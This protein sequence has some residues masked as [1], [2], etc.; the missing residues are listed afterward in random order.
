M[1]PAIAAAFSFDES[2]ELVERARPASCVAF[3]G[4]FVPE[5][6]MREGELGSSI[7]RSQIDFDTRL[8]AGFI[9]AARQHHR[10]KQRFR[11][12]IF[13]FRRRLQRSSAAAAGRRTSA[14]TR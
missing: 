5:G 13:P 4:G 8:F 14:A 6:R 1:W 7:D 2:N 9:G 3:L 12:F 11:R 10:A